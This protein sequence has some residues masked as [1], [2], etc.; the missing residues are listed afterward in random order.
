MRPHHDHKHW[1]TDW[2]RSKMVTAEDREKKLSAV[3]GKMKNGADELYSSPSHPPFP[4]HCR[5][6]PCHSV[7]HNYIHVL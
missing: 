3:L 7:Y 5:K 4:T 1:I 2:I 6:V